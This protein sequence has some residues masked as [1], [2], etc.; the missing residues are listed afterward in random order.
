MSSKPVS[1]H[2]EADALRR[3]AAL[4]RHRA[5][6][7][8][9]T[10]I[11]LQQSAHFGVV[12]GKQY[13][14]HMHTITGGSPVG[15]R[16]GKDSRS[17]CR[18]VLGSSVSSLHLRWERTL[19]QFHF[20]LG[21]APALLSGPLSAFGADGQDRW[22]LLRWLTDHRDVTP[23]RDQ[24]LRPVVDAALAQLGERQVRTPVCRQT[25]WAQNSAGDDGLSGVLHDSC[26]TRT[27]Y[28]QDR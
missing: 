17:G 27:G 2:G 22:T 25:D 26:S 7:A 18:P 1:N 15:G 16:L 19:R 12:V 11:V 8:P 5:V 24:G 6:D 13:A 23:E 9:G 20:V 4:M 14:G 28:V 10:Q 21:L 3:G